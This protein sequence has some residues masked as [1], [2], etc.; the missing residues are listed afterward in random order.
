MQR[1]TSPQGRCFTRTNIIVFNRRREFSYIYF[2]C[3]IMSVFPLNN[4]FCGSNRRTIIPL[5]PYLPYYFVSVFVSKQWQHK[6]SEPTTNGLLHI[7]CVIYMDL[8]K[9]CLQLNP[10]I[11]C[12]YYIIFEYECPSLFIQLLYRNDHPAHTVSYNNETKIVIT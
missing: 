9:Y 8:H 5:F 7:C 12:F 3:S 6:V 4:G 11:L 10:L 1:I 2:F